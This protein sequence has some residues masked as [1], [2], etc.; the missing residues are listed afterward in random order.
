MSETIRTT[1][2]KALR[3]NLDLERYGAFAEIG[4]GQE[5]ARHFFQA[6]RAS[7]TIAKSMSAYDM[8]YSDEIYGR[9]KNGRYVCESRLAKMLEKE[10]S[11]LIRRLDE[12]RGAQTRFFAFANT[13]ATGSPET[14]KCHGWMGIRYQSKPRGPFNDIILHVRMTDRLRLQQQEA[15]G[16]LGV[17]LIEAAF[18]GTQSPE[19]FLNEL[20]ANLKAGQVIID[21][22]RFSGP[23]LADFENRRMNL[24]LVRRGLAEAALFAPNGEVMNMADAVWGKSLLIQ[25]GTFRPY[26]LTHADVIH[27]GLAQLKAEAPKMTEKKTEVMALCEIVMPKDAKL[28]ELPDLE[29]RL[30]ALGAMGHHTLVSNFPLYYRLKHF[31]RLFTPMPMALIMG[32]SKLDK[33]FDEKPYADLEGGT[34]EGLGKLFDQQT[35]L[36]VYPHK[37]EKICLTAKVFSPA[38]PAAKIYD[39]FRGQRQILDISGCDEADVY[40]HSAD[41]RKLIEKK[42]RSWEKLVPAPVISLVKKRKIWGF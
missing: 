33:L 32:A 19:R 27:K 34:L 41:V 38:G 24:E 13:V 20:V 39:Y 8:T 30:D 31:I 22:M 14:P 29:N 3:V 42:D 16:I 2:A 10:Y 23:D 4:A 9:E 15:L 17:N 21:L 6:G 36:Y 11:L 26:T 35:K 12:K 5:V 1:A 40:W 25:R 28:K 7:Q 37:T 18:Y